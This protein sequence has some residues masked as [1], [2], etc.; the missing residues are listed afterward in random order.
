[1]EYQPK[2]PGKHHVEVVLRNKEK[3]LDFEHIQNS[4]IDVDIKAGTDASH[5]VAEGPGLKDGILDTAPAEFTIFARD[6]DDKPIQEGGDP[7]QVSVIGPDGVECPLEIVDN[8]DGTYAV[9][10]HPQGDGPH[11]V[12]VTLN[13]DH[14]KDCPKTVNIKPGAWPKNCLI[15]NFTLLVRT[16]DKRGEDLKEGGQNVKTAITNPNSQPVETVKTIDKKDGTY[17]IEYD[18]PRL[19]GRYL[20]TCTIDDQNIKGSPFDQSVENI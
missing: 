9:V 2:E 20:I 19:A 17:L 5:C 15:E 3:P 11:K 16:R 4:P 6:R 1:V 7:F 13:D 12:D 10:Y 14:I 18:L 8:N